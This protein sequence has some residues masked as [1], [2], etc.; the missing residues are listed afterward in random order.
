MDEQ[1]VRRI[2]ALFAACAVLAAC[3]AQM[4]KAESDLAQ[5]EEWLPGRYDN[6]EQAEADARAGRDPH[7]ALT[8]SIVPVD[9]PLFSRHLYYLQEG[10]ADDA[11]RVTMQR[12][13][14]FEVVKDGRILQTVYSL[15]Q[16]GRW[17]DGSLNP[18]LFKGLMIQDTNPLNGCALEWKREGARFVAANQRAT[19][20]VTSAAAGGNVRMDMRI[21]LTTDEIATAELA[22]GAND[23]LVQGNAAEPFYRFRK[24]SNP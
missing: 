16:P 23:T 14:S 1:R 4:K 19:C 22:Y 20:R 2:G 10:V 15:A 12:L 18:D 24:R 17:R 11:R 6:L 3:G 9:A 8:L 7:T 13:L 5:I 21:E